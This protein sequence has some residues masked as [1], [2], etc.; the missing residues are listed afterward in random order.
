[1]LKRLAAFCYYRRRYVVVAWIVLLV[2][3][4][5]ASGALGPSFK[6]G[7]ELPDSES[8]EVVEI[9][10]QAGFAYRA[11]SQGQVVFSAAQG[12]GDPEVR[13]AMEEFFT[14]VEREVEGSEVVSPYEN[15]REGQIAREGTIAYAEVNLTERSQEDYAAAAGEIKALRSRVDVPGVQIEL[16]GDVFSQEDGT[17]SDAVGLVG[18]IV[19]LL[20]AFGS[21]LAM[22]LPIMTAL[23]GIGTGMALVGL[24]TQFVDMP[25]FTAHATTMIGIGVGIDY[26]L[27]IVTRYR[28]VLASGR[29]PEDAVIT[30][31]D[32]SGR[33]VLFAGVTV[34]ISLLGLVFMGL[35]IMRGLAV[36]AS[37]GV[38]M[39]M[40][41]SVTLLPAIL[42]FVGRN[43][44]R[45]GLPHRKGT[46]RVSLWY[47]W[48]R[49]VQRRPLLGAA[50][51]L[52]ILVVA[53]L[54]VFSMRLGFADAASAPRSD[55]TRRAYDLLSDGF[56]PGFNGPLL[57]AAELD[58]GIDIADLERLSDRLNRT[59]GVA[60]ASSPTPSRTGEAAIIQ[61]VPTTSPQDE[62]TVELVDRLRDSVVP[63]AMGAGRD[64]VRIGGLTAAAIDFAG[65]TAERLPVFITLVLVL[66]FVLLMAVFRSLLVPLKAVLM[67]LLSIG[68]AYGVIVAVFQWG[69]AGDFFGIGAAAP[70]EAWAPMMLFAIVFGLSMDYEVFLLSRVREAYDRTGDN[71]EAVADGLAATARVISAAA[72]IMVFVFGSFALG[73]VR[74]IKLFGLGLAIA[75]LVDAT[76][77]RLLLVPATMELLGDR[78][79]WIPR[80]LDRAIPSLRVDT[81]HVTAEGPAG[82]SP[83]RRTT[84]VGAQEAEGRP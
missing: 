28:E 50:A 78:N 20:I 82:A 4:N 29:T 79:W 11:G 63:E 38:L 26:A 27:F 24:A 30:A 31:V 56:G 22:G 8:Q 34:V 66:S 47:R 68:V 42:G 69:W 49:V 39:T 5:G 9:L 52:A 40:A 41:A 14:S 33:A 6:T 23:F 2:V 46:N 16:G 51:G 1:M 54:P 64:S 61:I 21:V 36:G 44:D 10:D 55:T 65:Y 17:P 80:W 13:S 67:N 83:S 77:V 45:L 84:V 72:A 3:L 19:I 48:S 71:R 70:V 43:I 35:D 75:V 7:F 15:G 76:V 81:P 57:A 25:D 32:T 12:A 60:L 58:S 53:A 74:E 73:D 18:A 37:T 59:N 62:E